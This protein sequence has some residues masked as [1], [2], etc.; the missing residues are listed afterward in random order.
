MERR[1]ACLF[2]RGNLRQRRGTA[3]SLR[4]QAAASS[5]LLVY[6]SKATAQR[7]GALRVLP[8]E[9]LRWHR[10]VGVLHR[11][12]PYLSPAIRRFIDILRKVAPN[13]AALGWEGR[14][15]D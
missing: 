6:T 13:S 11:K 14:S 1:A 7:F 5:D 12:E 8:V 4:L 9:E 2:D 15:Q 3:L 10:S